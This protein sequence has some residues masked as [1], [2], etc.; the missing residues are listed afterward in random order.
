MHITKNGGKG[1][2]YEPN[3]L[4]GPVEDKSKEIASYPVSGAAGRYPHSHNNDNY[5]QPRA[6]FRDVFNE[7]ERERLIANIVGSLG[8]CRKNIQETAVAHLFKIDPEY[9]AGVAKG[10]GVSVPSE[11]ESSK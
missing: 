10:V 2:N 11:K 3:S 4:N 9:G 8:Q 1:P 7:G 5:V 6:L